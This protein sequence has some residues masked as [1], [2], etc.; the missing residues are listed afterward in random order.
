M[1]SREED[2]AEER[3][4]IAET[5]EAEAVADVDAKT[6]TAGTEAGPFDDRLEMVA[7]QNLH[8]EHMAK[9][10]GGFAALGQF[11][12]LGREEREFADFPGVGGCTWFDERID[13]EAGGETVGVATGVFILERQNVG[14]R[15]VQG[16]RS[17]G[18][19]TPTGKPAAEGCE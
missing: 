3:V 17:V 11:G 1:A 7:L 6:H 8:S 19:R 4:P 18:I 12:G 14:D 15:V 2:L 10:I 13:E 9:V 16:G 5:K